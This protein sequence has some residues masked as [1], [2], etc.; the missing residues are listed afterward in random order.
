[1]FRNDDTAPKGD[2]SL[3]PWYAKRTDTSLYTAEGTLTRII[4]QVQGLSEGQDALSKSKSV[5]AIKCAPARPDGEADGCDSLLR[6][7]R[8][9]P[10]A[11]STP[12][13]DPPESR[14]FR[15]A[16]CHHRRV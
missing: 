9:T 12:R 2:A 15:G 3:I 16:S 10:G 7:R 13:P 8:C 1:M 6:D 14:Q 5:S 11:E 4:S